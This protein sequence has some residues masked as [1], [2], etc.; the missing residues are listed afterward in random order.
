[1][2]DAKPATDD[3]IARIKTAAQVHVGHLTQGQLVLR[4][5]ARIDTERAARLAAEA[6]VKVLEDGL[7]LGLQQLEAK[8]IV[9]FIEQGH[10]RWRCF[11]CDKTWS[12]GFDEIHRQSCSIVHMRA[13]LKESANG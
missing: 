4:L 6:R 2:T 3:E 1:M 10:D 13:A 11:E 7:K 9:P 8:Q 12:E 5:V